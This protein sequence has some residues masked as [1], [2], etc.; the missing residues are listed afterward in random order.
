MNIRLIT[1][2]IFGIGFAIFLFSL[3]LNIQHWPGAKITRIIGVFFIVFGSITRL[4]PAFK[5]V[6]NPK[7]DKDILD[8]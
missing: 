8:S 5:K 4:T 3:I 7:T 2:F 1:H 6:K